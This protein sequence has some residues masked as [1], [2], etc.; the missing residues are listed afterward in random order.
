M[1]ASS[2]TTNEVATKRTYDPSVIPPCEA[3][4]GPRAFECQLMPNLINV[5]RATSS[6]TS[7]KKAPKQTDQERRAEVARLLRSEEVATLDT[8]VSGE[9]ADTAKEDSA[10]AKGDMEWG[11]CMVFSCIADCCRALDDSK[12]PGVWKDVEAGWKEE[13]VLVQW[14]A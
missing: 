9:G 12:G 10:A 6:K 13:V 3:C 8:V 4:G 11:T 7:S 2:T 5:F 14:D 1:P